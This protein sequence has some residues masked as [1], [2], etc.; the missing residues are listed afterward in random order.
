M[1]VMHG[2]QAIPEIAKSV[3]GVK[4]LVFS[5]DDAD[6]LRREVLRRGAHGYVS[7]SSPITALIDEVNNLLT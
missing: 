5:T 2:L 3:P 7:K 4:I 6:E 1:P